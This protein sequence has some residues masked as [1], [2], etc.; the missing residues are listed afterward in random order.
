MKKLMLTICLLVSLLLAGCGNYIAI[1][2]GGSAD[3]GAMSLAIEDSK[4]IEEIG[5]DSLSAVGFTCTLEGS[6]ASY[7][8]TTDGDY[9]GL[10]EWERSIGTLQEIG[11]YRDGPE[12]GLYWKQGIEIMENSGLFATV[13]GGFTFTSEV[14]VYESTIRVYPYSYGDTSWELYGIY[15]VGLTYFFE[16]KN[17][18]LV[19][20]YDNRRE[21][22]M[23][24]GCRF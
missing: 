8:V 14:T 17:T 5:R 12:F 22:C 1:T 23:G 11:T 16:G 21:L 24:F 3:G 6:D 20:D 13:H 9:A 18:S 4:I 19:V 2:G 15:G 10:Y 7:D